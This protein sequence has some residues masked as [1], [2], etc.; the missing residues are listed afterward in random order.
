M[1]MLYTMNR[2][3]SVDLQTI[4]SRYRIS[5][6]KTFEL[7]L[8]NLLLFMKIAAY[9]R[10]DAKRK[11][12][13]HLPS[14]EDRKFTPKLAENPLM[15]SLLQNQALFRQFKK[16]NLEEKF[17]EDQIR[18]F[19]SEFS[20]SEEYHAFIDKSDNTQQEFINIL[21]HLYKTCTSNESFIEIITDNYPLW[22]E[23]K[24]LVVGAIKKTIKAL[25]AEENFYQA[26]I[27]TAETIDEFGKT[28]LVEVSQK[29]T[30]L[31]EVITPA[32]KNW[33]A[34]RVAVIDMILIK[35]AISEFIAFESIPTK[36][37][38]NEYVEL[39]KVYST[40][41]SKDF[42]NGILDRLVKQLTENG[43][44][45]KTGRGLVGN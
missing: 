40:D 20:G 31:L 8:F 5:I 32:L 27:P 33:D 43:K 4:L 28:L 37:T 24:S 12:S 38:L 22:E 19:Y 42:V 11:K 18:R 30:E 21:L 1:Q 26:Y 13:K 35:M 45:Q 9:A 29:E 25:P 39:A 44:I 3:K 10:I 6:D 14:E 23:D 17:D 7:F 36:V 2:D 15:N 34:D 41:K 16:M